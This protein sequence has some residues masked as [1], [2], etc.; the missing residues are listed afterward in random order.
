MG[1]SPSKEHGNNCYGTFVDA[2]LEIGPRL[3]GIIFYGF[4]VADH[5]LHRERERAIFLGHY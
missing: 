4:T 3:G 2:F 5:I 1:V